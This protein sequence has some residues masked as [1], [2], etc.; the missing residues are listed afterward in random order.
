MNYLVDLVEIKPRSSCKSSTF[1]H[2]SIPPVVSEG[3]CHRFLA[4]CAQT[5]YRGNGRM[6]Q[7]ASSCIMDNQETGRKDGM[8]ERTRLKPSYRHITSDVSLRLRPPC[9]LSLP[10]RTNCAWIE[11][12]AGRS[13]HDRI[14]SG[15]NL[16]DIP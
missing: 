3:S 7:M 15:N 4:P 14:T 8:E 1:S 13:P 10:H 9:L 5:D 2:Q 16:T 12:F 11:T 6:T